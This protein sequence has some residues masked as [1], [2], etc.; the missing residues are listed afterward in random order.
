MGFNTPLLREFGLPPVLRVD[1]DVHQARDGGHD[2]R[3]RRR[4]IRFENLDDARIF[5]MTPAVA[6]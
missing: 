6:S 4:G 2:E 5:G 3:R 1:R